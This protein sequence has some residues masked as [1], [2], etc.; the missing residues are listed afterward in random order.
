MNAKEEFLLGLLFGGIYKSVC[1]MCV[2]V[3][4]CVCVCDLV[5]FVIPE[6]VIK[7]SFNIYVHPHRVLSFLLSF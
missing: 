5:A 1:N 6:T 2:C 7:E 4:V 3:C